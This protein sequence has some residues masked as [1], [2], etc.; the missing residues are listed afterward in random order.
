ME[1]RF[2]SHLI[3][4]LVPLG[5]G[6]KVVSQGGGGF[7]SKVMLK[8]RDIGVGDGVSHPVCDD[9]KGPFSL[10]TCHL[11]RFRVCY[12]MVDATGFFSRPKKAQGS[13]PWACFKEQIITNELY[14]PHH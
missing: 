14:R 10:F 9:M 1:L 6:S 12:E 4:P 13:E 2:L 7:E 8:R 5:K 11:W 3:E